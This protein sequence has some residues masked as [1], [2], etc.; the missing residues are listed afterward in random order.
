M[1]FKLKLTSNFWNW[2]QGFW[3]HETI[4]VSINPHECVFLFFSSLIRFIPPP[5]DNEW[6][7]LYRGKRIELTVFTFGKLNFSSATKPVFPNLNGSG[8]Q[9]SFTL[10]LNIFIYFLLRLQGYRP[11]KLIIELSWI[12]TT[13]EKGVINKGFSRR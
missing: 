4:I 12:T 10:S 11:G 9:Q 5:P 6:V 1:Q 13:G 8:R 3:I 2:T 7:V